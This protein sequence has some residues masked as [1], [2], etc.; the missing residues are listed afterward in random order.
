[1][2]HTITDEDP[3]S[4]SRFASV[5][6]WLV[7]NNVWGSVCRYLFALQTCIYPNVH[8]RTLSRLR[9]QHR[10]FHSSLSFGNRAVSL[11]RLPVS[12]VRFSTSY[13]FQIKN[14]KPVFGWFWF[15]VACEWFYIRPQRPF[16]AVH[17]VFRDEPLSIPMW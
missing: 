6:A 12:R 15:L 17:I 2:V 13:S 14:A 11:I 5:L 8:E 16:V 10:V 7:C 1:M 4:A 9:N 3:K